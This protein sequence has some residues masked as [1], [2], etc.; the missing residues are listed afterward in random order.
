MCMCAYMS[1][2]CH[3]IY[4]NNLIDNNNDNICMLKLFDIVHIILKGS[5]T[6]L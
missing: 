4:N 2:L 3:I 5:Y 6:K 1:S